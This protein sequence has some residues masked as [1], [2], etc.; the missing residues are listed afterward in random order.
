MNRVQYNRSEKGKSD[1]TMN[2]VQ[3][4]ADVLDINGVEFFEIKN[5]DIEVHTVNEPL[6]QKVRLFEELDELQKKRYL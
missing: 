6:L 2:N 3:C 5:D 4:I 1:P